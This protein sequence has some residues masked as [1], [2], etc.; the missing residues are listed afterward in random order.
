MGAEGLSGG[1]DSATRVDMRAELAEQWAKA[2]LGYPVRLVLEVERIDN[3]KE[4][5]L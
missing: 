5:W 4:S 1:R 3:G 2:V